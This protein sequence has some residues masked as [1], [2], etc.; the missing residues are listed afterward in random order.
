M[1]IPLFLSKN[2]KKSEQSIHQSLDHA[3]SI[4]TNEKLSNS[5]ILELR[6][7]KNDSITQNMAHFFTRL[8]LL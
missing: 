5:D 6:Q 8:S 4:S 1:Y 7:Y 3:L 2:R